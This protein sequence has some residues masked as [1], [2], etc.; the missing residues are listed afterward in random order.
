MWVGVSFVPRLSCAGR[1]VRGP[2]WDSPEARLSAGVSPAGVCSCLVW[3]GRSLTGPGGLPR[4]VWRPFFDLGGCPPLP[5]PGGSAACNGGW[6]EGRRGRCPP[7]LFFA[8]FVG[9]RSRPSRW[10]PFV[11]CGGRDCGCGSR[12]CCVVVHWWSL[13]HVLVGVLLVPPP[14]RFFLCVPCCVRVP[15]PPAGEV[16][17]GVSGVSFSPT[18]RWLRG[19]GGLFFLAGRCWAGRCGL[20]VSY[21]WVPWMSPVVLPGW[22]GC[23]PWWSGC[24]AWRLRGC[25]SWFR[26]LPLFLPLPSLGRCMHWS[27]SGV[28]NWLRVRVAGGHGPCPGSVRL[29]A[30]VHAR[31]GGSY[32]WVMLRFS[33]LGGRATWFRAVMGQGWRRVAG[34]VLWGGVAPCTPAPVVSVRC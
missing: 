20:S 4:L 26:P 6:C 1:A 12:S 30:Y 10:G 9:V 13:S 25:P 3:G 15:V 18:H 2:G 11:G 8:V 23:P 31:A 19:R 7:P 16:C 22:G 27:V 21:H 5:L 34:A 33:L 14:L 17:A 29:A 28:A 24:V 32:C